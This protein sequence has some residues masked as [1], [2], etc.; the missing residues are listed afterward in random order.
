MRSAVQ[1]VCQS[2]SPPALRQRTLEQAKLLLIGHAWTGH[3]GARELLELLF[4]EPPKTNS[5]SHV[6]TD[7][8]A[9][10]LTTV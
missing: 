4:P 1:K 3:R 7:S 8:L 9:P 10:P 2:Y 6:A 5:P